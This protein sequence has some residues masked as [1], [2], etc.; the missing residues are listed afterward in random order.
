[1][2]SAIV[3]Q[4]SNNGYGIFKG[5]YDISTIEKFSELCEK[6]SINRPF[7]KA[8]G[9]KIMVKSAKN[10]VAKTR[11]FDDFFADSR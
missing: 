2:L 9:R 5:F 8:N 10:L 3:E 6:H 7:T 1:M 11:D 4:I